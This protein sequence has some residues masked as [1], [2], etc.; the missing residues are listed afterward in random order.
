MPLPGGQA[1][2]YSNAWRHLRT[3][4]RHNLTCFCLKSVRNAQDAMKCAEIPV[5]HAFIIGTEP[6][7]NQVAVLHFIDAA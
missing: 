4:Q 7:G 3:I 1:W 5:D 6:R 2:Y